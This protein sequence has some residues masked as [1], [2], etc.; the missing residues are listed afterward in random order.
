MLG[1]MFKRNVAIFMSAMMIVGL[2]N[3][4]PISAQAAEKLVKKLSVSKACVEIEEGESD[5]VKYQIKADGDASK[6]VTVKVADK[7]VASVKKSSGKI[8]ITGKSEGETTVTIATKAKNKKG[9]RLAKKIRV[10]VENDDFD[11]SE[12]DYSDDEDVVNENTQQ[13]TNTQIPIKETRQETTTEEVSKITEV[14]TE[15]INETTEV[16]TVEVVKEEVVPSI[17]YQA[18]I[19]TNGWIATVK[20]GATAGS[21]GQ[22]KRLEGIK[23]VLNDQNGNSMITYRAH[24]QGP[25]WQDWKKSGELAGTEK[26]SKRMEGIMIKLTGEYAEKYDVYYRAHVAHFGWLGW[27]KNGELAGSECISLAM[28][29]IQIKLV[30]KGESFNAGGKAAIV[31]PK[32]TYQAHC[33]DYGWRPTVGEGSTAGTTGESRRLEGL[34]IDLLNLDGSNGIEYRAHIQGPGWQDW[35]KSGELAGTENAAKRMEAIQIKLK[36]D[37]ANYF[38]IYY[39]MHVEGYGWLGWAKNGEVAGTTGCSA[40]AEAIEIVLTYKEKDFDCGGA[41]YHDTKKT[42]SASSKAEVLVNLAASQV[43]YYEKATNSNLD[44]F[45]ANRGSNNYNKY[46]RDI[47]VANGQAWCATFVWWLMRTAGVSEGAYPA[48]TTATRDW[49][50]D[51]GLYRARGTYTPKPGDYIVFEN[52]SHCGIVESVSGGYVTTIEGNSSDQVKRNRYSLDNSRI[53]GYGIINY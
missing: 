15:T 30:K 49:F 39:R 18:H 3:V 10:I 23:I 25:G 43:G 24:V 13:T 22:S 52:V 26:A 2:V 11:E 35:K 36:G 8:I 5:K 31:K 20:D 12:L 51:R 46:A 33:Q 38:D 45:T 17:S 53:L 6:K 32:L 1:K 16:P 47:G 40:R 21:T 48:R 19:Q 29:A 9:K 42:D 7:A 50:N 27:A 41:A 4:S 14:S 34:K 28:E 37:L 44:D